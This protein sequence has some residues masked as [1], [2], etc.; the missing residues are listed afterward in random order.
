MRIS[1]GA[2]AGGA[3][4]PNSD[5]SRQKKDRECNGHARKLT[6]EQ[7][8][9]LRALMDYRGWEAIQIQARYGIDADT[10]RRY[11]NGITRAKLK[12]SEEDLPDEYK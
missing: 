2:I 5:I 7:I 3:F 10:A 6:D 9:E 1:Y 8:K 11:M 4:R 12:Y